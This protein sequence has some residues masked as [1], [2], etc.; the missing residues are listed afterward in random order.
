MLFLGVRNMA[1]ILYV[2]FYSLPDKDAAANRVINNAKA[3]REAGHKVWFL[4]EQRDC[5]DNVLETK[6]ELLGFQSWSTLRPNGFLGLLRKMTS[7]KQIIS[8]I[9]EI[10]NLDLIIVYNY[11]SIALMSLSNYCRKHDIKIASDCSEWYSGKDYNFP[12]SILSSVDSCLRM[13]LVQKNLDGI[14]VIS[15]YLQNYYSKCKNVISIPPLV[16]ISDSKWNQNKYHFDENKLNLVYTGNLGRSKETFFPIIE[17]IDKSINQKR[18][19]FR[20]VGATKEEFL[21][22]CPNA[23]DRLDRMK[24]SIIFYGRVSHTESLRI[25]RSSDYIIFLRD[26]NRV[27]MAGFSTKFVEALSCGTPVITTNTGDIMQYVNK[28]DCGYIIDDEH[29]LSLL[30]NKDTAELKSKKNSIKNTELF[31]FRQYVAVFKK[32]IN[33]IIG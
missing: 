25:L 33:D 6:H 17:A 7:I 8:V 14:I 27:T 22:I 30:L 15:S 1:N 10:N 12:M 5:V 19:V 16:D 26:R 18:I 32:W 28:L 31:D 11:P 2:G 20:V 29:P 4:D 24:D 3:L 9:E 13:R 21:Q 23:E